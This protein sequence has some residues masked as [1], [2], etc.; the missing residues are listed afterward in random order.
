MIPNETLDFGIESR[1]HEAFFEIF[2][3]N[4]HIERVTLFGSRAKGTQKPFS[5]IDF[6]IYGPELNELDAQRIK[7]DLE[8]LYH[9]YFIDMLAFS[10]VSN[11]ALKQE[12]LKY[13]K[14]Y[15]EKPS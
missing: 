8:E 6:C 2:R 5:D 11:S 14:P 1:W 3:Q 10:S 7:S 4:P 15:Y 9:P 13:E 12:I